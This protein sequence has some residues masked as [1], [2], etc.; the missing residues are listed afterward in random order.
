MWVS[1]HFHGKID[2]T[3]IEFGNAYNQLLFTTTVDLA[4]VLIDQLKHELKTATRRLVTLAMERG[5]GVLADAFYEGDGLARSEIV[6]GADDTFIKASELKLPKDSDLSIF[7]DI[8]E[9]VSDLKHYGFFLPD[10][11]LLSSA[12]DVLDDL[13]VHTEVADSRYLHR[14][15]ELPSLLE[16]AAQFQAPA[17]RNSGNRS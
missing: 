1:S 8:T 17:G 9:G 2:R 6:L 7:D 4:A 16:H 3:S 5:S 14:P 15:S 13:A 11:L 10:R 12:R